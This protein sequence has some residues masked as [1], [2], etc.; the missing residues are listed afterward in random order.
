MMD[1]ANECPFELTGADFYALCTDAM[2]KAISKSIAN[3]QQQFGILSHL[4]T[5][6]SATFKTDN[7]NSDI[8]EK[9]FLDKLVHGEDKLV[10]VDFEDFLNA[11]RNLQPSV[12]KYELKRY[13]ELRNTFSST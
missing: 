4:P 1:V 10:L 9:V 3:L 11:L 7:E 6:F 5:Y 2:L 12:K 13:E 8:T